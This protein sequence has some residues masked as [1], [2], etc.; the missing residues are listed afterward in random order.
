MM[1]KM[2]KFVFFFTNGSAVLYDKKNI[3]FV[4][5]TMKDIAS[6]FDKENSILYMIYSNYAI[7]IKNFS[8]YLFSRLDSMIKNETTVNNTIQSCFS[9]NELLAH[10][11]TLIKKKKR[12]K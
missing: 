4:T 11:R 5:G 6:H 7:L 8:S 12:S 10:F 1:L 2:P 9:M 3:Y